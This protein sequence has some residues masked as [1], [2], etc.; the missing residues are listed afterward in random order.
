MAEPDR[1]VPVADVAQV[2]TRPR[3]VTVAGC[4]LVVLRP[5]PG[6]PAVV[7]ADRCP[8]RMVPLS[9]GVVADGRLRCAYH[10]WEFGPDGRCAQVPSAGPDS[11]P[12]PRAD[13]AAVRR[14]T[15]DGGM[16]RVHRDDLAGLAKSGPV[17]GLSNTDRALRY[18]WHPVGLVSEFGARS[19][20]VR[21]LGEEWIVQTRDG[22]WGVQPEPWG[23]RE[24]W[25]LLWLAPAPPLVEI[26]DEPDG[27]DAAY[28]GAWLPPARTPAPAGVVADNFLD[29]AHFPFVHANTFG[30]TGERVVP[31]YDVVA[32][33][34][35]CRSVQEQWFDNPQDPGVAAG[36]RPARQ[37][38]RATYVYRA[39][40]Q[41]LL[42]LE[43][44]DAGAVKTIVFLVQ[45]ET[46]TSTRIY[47]KMLLAG[48]GG[49]RRP[50]PQA[51]AAEV[52]FE[53]AVLAEDLALQRRMTLPVLPL[54][55][56][57]ELHVR[58]DRLGVALR[59]ELARF[60]AR[61]EGLS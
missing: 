12:P 55:L 32:E 6:A 45:P 13:L 52:A 30:A 58:A 31:P 50:G 56:R 25:G 40:F 38:R 44:L 53:E 26:F 29:V 23:L 22:Q 54:R 28:V 37:R 11:D 9:A 24:R 27:D 2:G 59:R 33:P 3:A 10:G 47:T 17:P 34:D 21:L 57:T 4:P 36:L 18:A 19:R 51:V 46:S 5:A 60:V 61:G 35:G 8:H 14:V 16:I 49:V 20:P 48:I 42:R 43:E 15:E 41:L 7:F 39:P 1:W